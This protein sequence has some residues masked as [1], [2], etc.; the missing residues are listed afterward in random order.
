MVIS[1]FRS[2]SSLSNVDVGGVENAPIET[3]SRQLQA[4]R[5]IRDPFYRENV[6]SI[7]DAVITRGQAIEVMKYFNR[8][9]EQNEVELNGM[10]FIRK[11]DDKNM[12]YLSVSGR[13]WDG[14]WLFGDFN[15][16][17]II[18]LTNTHLGGLDKRD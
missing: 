13:Q 2:S 10:T 8:H 16:W 1:A 6:V 3:N 15:R 14:F 11:T 5:Q 9:P 4:Q 12:P 18:N 17:G 7:G